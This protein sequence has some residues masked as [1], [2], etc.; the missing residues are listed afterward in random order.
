MLDETHAAE[1]KLNESTMR[2]ILLK[3]LYNM[4]NGKR[5]RN[6]LDFSKAEIKFVRCTQDAQDVIEI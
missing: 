4:V 6:S 3:I 2:G 1:H 5:K